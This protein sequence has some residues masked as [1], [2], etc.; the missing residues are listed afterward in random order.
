MNSEGKALETGRELLTENLDFSNYTASLAAEALRCGIYTDEDMERI[1]VEVLETLSEVIGMYTQQK[2]TSV[3]TERAAELTKS[4]LYNVDVYL[5]SLKNTGEACKV[6]RERKMSE[7]YGK[8]Y[9]I[10]KGLYEEAKR[11]YSRA[12]YTR[13]KN[14]SIAYD[15]VLDQYLY[16]YL[17]DYDPRFSA[18][19][20][21]YVNL[22]ELGFKGGYRMDGVVKMLRAIVDFNAGKKSDVVM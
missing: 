13:R 11:L 2:S 9:L 15:K 12:K 3:R 10:N 16:Y 7:L 20:R 18:H 14:V 1:Q 6:L 19:D 17:R 5:R 4:L 21:L 22:T 8:G